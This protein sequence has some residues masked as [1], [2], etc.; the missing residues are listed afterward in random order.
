M[1][2][3]R[4]LTY[5]EWVHQH[6]DKSQV[7][8][9]SRCR[10]GGRDEWISSIR[11]SKGVLVGG[12]VQHRADDPISR[13]LLGTG[14]LPTPNSVSGCNSTVSSSS[15]PACYVKTVSPST[16]WREELFRID[17]QLTP[18]QLLTFRLI[19]DTWDTTVLTPQWGMVLNSFPTVQ[20]HIDGPGISMI[21]GLSGMLPKGFMSHVSFSYVAEHVTL[22]GHGGRLHD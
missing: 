22:T 7:S 5:H 1:S 9:L 12:G 21:A 6:E 17:H 4:V 13:A 14:L 3:R 19:H 11:I 15:N 8:R 20:N 18:S 16:S 2:A 10:E